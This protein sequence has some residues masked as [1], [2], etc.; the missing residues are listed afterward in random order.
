[1]YERERKR[2]GCDEFRVMTEG[3][4]RCG[5]LLTWDDKNTMVMVVR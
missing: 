3:G 4:R 5:V 1:M 2:R